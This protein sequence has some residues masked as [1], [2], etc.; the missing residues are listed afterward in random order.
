LRLEVKTERLELS[1]DTFSRNP[2]NQQLV[3]AIRELPEPPETAKRP[4]GF[5][6]HEEK[7]NTKSSK[8]SAKQNAARLR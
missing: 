5:V 1:H 4:I 7:K 3:E 2:R 6:S 8:G